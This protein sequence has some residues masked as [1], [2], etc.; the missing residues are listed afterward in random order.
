MRPRR[1]YPRDYRLRVL[2]ALC[3]L[4]VPGKRTSMQQIAELAQVPPPVY[5]FMI[6]LETSGHVMRKGASGVPEWVPVLRA[7][8]S[9]YVRMP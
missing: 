2:Q 5:P 7:D 3:A 8:G 4:Y 1:A 6:S 9:P